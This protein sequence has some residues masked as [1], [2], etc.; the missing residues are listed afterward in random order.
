[1]PLTCGRRFRTKSKLGAYGDAVQEID[2]TVGELVNALRDTGQ[3]ENTLVM[4]TSDNGP[5]YEGSAGPLRG[6]KADSWDGGMRVPFLAA[7]PSRIPAGKVVN[8]MSNAMDLMPTLARLC[9]APL[10]SAP[11]DGVDI[12]T[13]LTSEADEVAHPVFLYFYGDQLQ[14]GRVGKWKL[15]IARNSGFS[16]A[17]TP[18]TGFLNL[19]LYKPELYD[20]E[21]DPGENYDCSSENP[22]IVSYIRERM[23]E[24]ISTFPASIQKAFADTQNRKVYPTPPGALPI[25]RR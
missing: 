5:W 20:L 1:L 6:R 10:P 4:F 12:W 23:L 13:M 17:P 24:Q 7:M 8:G 9:D 16:W 2:W 21:A 11:L 22:D 14:C 15:H 18:E 3:E 25:E 19:P